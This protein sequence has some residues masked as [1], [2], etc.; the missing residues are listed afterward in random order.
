MSIP[1]NFDIDLYQILRHYDLWK[2]RTISITG[3]H[4]DLQV[5]KKKIPPISIYF[6]ISLNILIHNTDE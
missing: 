2:Y 6:I 3:R 5:E 1:H 4:L